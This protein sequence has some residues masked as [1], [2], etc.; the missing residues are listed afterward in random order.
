M[1]KVRESLAKII[2]FVGHMVACAHIMAYVLPNEL[3]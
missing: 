1:I 3:T 2:N